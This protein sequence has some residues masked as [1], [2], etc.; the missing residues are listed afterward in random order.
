MRPATRLGMSL[1]ACGCLQAITEGARVQYSVSQNVPKIARDVEGDTYLACLDPVSRF[2]P[3][4][5]EPFRT[6]S[7]G[8]AASGRRLPRC[9]PD[10]LRGPPPRGVGRERDRGRRPRRP[11]AQT[12]EWHGSAPFDVQECSPAAAPIP[13]PIAQQRPTA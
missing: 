2:E 6:E 8:H 9:E 10:R 3:Q 5:S 7:Q 4:Q 12:N 1:W 11:R 13:E